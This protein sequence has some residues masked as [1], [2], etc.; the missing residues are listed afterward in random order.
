MFVQLERIEDHS[1]VVP[2]VDAVDEDAD[3]WIDR[4]NRA[5]DSEAANREVRR[6][7]ES[8]DVIQ[9][10]VRHVDCEAFEIANLQ[11]LELVRIESGHRQGHVLHELLALARRDR[12]FFHQHR[13]RTRLR[14]LRAS[15]V[16]GGN[17]GQD[18]T[19]AHHQAVAPADPPT[20]GVSAHVHGPS[21]SI[22]SARSCANPD[23][24]RLELAATVRSRE[25]ERN[26]ECAAP[27]CDYVQRAAAMSR[28]G[29]SAAR[30]P[31]SRAT[32]RCRSARRAGFRCAAAGYR[33]CS[34][35]R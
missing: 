17:T 21:S 14:F 25:E 20:G 28:A 22:G 11:R 31:A 13:R 16:R 9:R 5:V 23:D 27:R 15:E 19:H 2:H 7:G 10:D 30:R 26:W 8:A 32:R 33:A 12:D 18:E 29:A 3:R 35:A 4:R 1:Q 34:G 6:T 24:A